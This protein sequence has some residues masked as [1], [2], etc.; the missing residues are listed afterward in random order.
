MA[1]RPPQGSPRV[2]ARSGRWPAPLLTI[3]IPTYNRVGALEA[4]LAR[5]ARVDG[6]SL[7]VL[8]VDNAS[9]DG[10]AALLAR[11]APVPVQLV[12]QP[13][14]AGALRLHAGGV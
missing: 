14:G 11:L 6:A 3:G 12:C 10:T 13:V 1:P 5:L 9:T 8:V 7:E 2:S 4:Q